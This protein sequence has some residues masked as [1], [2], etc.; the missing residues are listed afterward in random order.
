MSQA[1]NAYYMI[2]AS[3]GFREKE[4]LRTK[5]RHNEVQALYNARKEIT[6]KLLRRNRTINDTVEVPDCPMR[7]LKFCIYRVECI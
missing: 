7:K 1:T 2:T 3:L 5:A 6:Q 4:R